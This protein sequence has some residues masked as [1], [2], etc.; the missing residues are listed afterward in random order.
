MHFTRIFLTFY[1]NDPFSLVSDK[2]VSLCSPS[3]PDIQRISEEQLLWKKVCREKRAQGK[4][5]FV[6]IVLIRSFSGPHFPALRLNE[7]K[8]GVSLH[9]QS[10]CGKIRTRK[11]PIR[12]IFTQY[13][14]L[15]KL[16]AL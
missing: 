15:V 1:S 10:E 13:S 6:K 9:I 4:L 2:E 11:T 5:H 12:T 8:Y 14:F 7:A 16:Q 3:K